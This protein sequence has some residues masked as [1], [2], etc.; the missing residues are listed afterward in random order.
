MWH[1]DTHSG[2]QSHPPKE[3]KKE[4]KKKKTRIRGHESPGEEAPRVP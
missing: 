3:K 4:E 2:K 1:T